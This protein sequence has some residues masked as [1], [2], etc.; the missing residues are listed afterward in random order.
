MLLTVQLY[1]N[2]IPKLIV[3]VLQKDP[4]VSVGFEVEG[5]VGAGAGSEGGEGDVG[6]LDKGYR[7][8]DV[9]C[10]RRKNPRLNRSR[11]RT[12]R[13]TAYVC[14]NY[15]RHGSGGAQR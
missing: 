14:V 1:S 3:R 15:C 7:V 6:G 11:I 2:E 5:N 13:C 8:P 10:G 4:V 9:S 12:H